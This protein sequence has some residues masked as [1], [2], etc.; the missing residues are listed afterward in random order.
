MF[1]VDLELLD[2]QIMCISKL[3]QQFNGCCRGKPKY[4]H[5]IRC[6]FYQ[7]RDV[8]VMK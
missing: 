5:N 8:G 1:D 3:L 2:S 4:V 7:L 6:E